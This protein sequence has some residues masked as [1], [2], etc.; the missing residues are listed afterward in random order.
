MREGREI[1][2][3][4]CVV[5]RTKGRRKERSTNL[6]VGSLGSSRVNHESNTKQSDEETNEHEPLW[7]EKEGR[8]RRQSKSQQ[9]NDASN[10]ASR[11]TH[12]VSSSGVHESSTEDGEDG[13]T[14]GLSEGEVGE[15]SVGPAE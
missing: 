8:K 6:S 2:D 12:L 3:V 11:A 10:Q 7:E 4:N 1:S 9:G 5:L 13:K 14:H 15:G